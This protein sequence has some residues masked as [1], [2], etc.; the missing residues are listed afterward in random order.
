M[1]QLVRPYVGVRDSYLAA[2]DEFQSEGRLDYYRPTELGREGGVSVKVE[3]EVGFSRYVQSLRDRA[4]EETERP[5]GHVPDTILWYVDG[6]EWI[7]RLDIRHRLTPALMEIGGHI[8]YDVRPSM[9][10]RGH[11]TRM[12]R[13]ALPMAAEL[14][15]NPVLVTCHVDNIA[16]RKVIEANGG[17]LE[18]KRSDR[19]RFWIATV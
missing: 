18:D 17:V 3:D 15:I 11:A 13:D 4:L 8:G 9:R 16:S 12:L 2:V 10:R 14:G 19:L 1:P 7:G 6:P 5:E